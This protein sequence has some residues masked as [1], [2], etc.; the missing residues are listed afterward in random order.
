MLSAAGRF[1]RDTPSFNTDSAD[2]TRASTAQK[3]SPTRRICS[4]ISGRLTSALAPTLV[5]SAARL[6]PRLPD[7]NSTL[8]SILPSKYVFFSILLFHY[9]ILKLLIFPTAFP[10]RSLLESLHPV[11]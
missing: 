2:A 8:T 10:V 11:F 6:S 1:F 9:V 4:A 5:P 7:S 3:S